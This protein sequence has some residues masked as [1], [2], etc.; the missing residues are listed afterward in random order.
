MPYSIVREWLVRMRGRRGLKTRFNRT[1]EAGKHDAQILSQD[2]SGV[3]QL[4]PKKYGFE[5]GSWQLNL[6]RE[7]IRWEFGRIA[8]RARCEE[9]SKGSGSPTK[10]LGRF[11]SSQPQKASKKS[12]RPRLAGG[13]GNLPGTVMPCSSKMRPQSVCRRRDLATGEVHGRARHHP[14]WLL[15]KGSL[16]A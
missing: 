10:K 1:R 5:S 13:Q 9:C 16:P 11:R 15:E 4:Q 12:S 14:Y 8:R 6:I 7:M 2:G 3:V